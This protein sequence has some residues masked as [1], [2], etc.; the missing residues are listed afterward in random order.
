MIHF[1]DKGN[2]KF[3]RGET[4]VITIYE[5]ITHADFSGSGRGRGACGWIP[6]YSH[7]LSEI[8]SDFAPIWAAY[9]RLLRISADISR[10]TDTINHT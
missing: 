1:L 6:I 5:T 10:F 4:E 9:N 7:V 8:L 2:R 3:V